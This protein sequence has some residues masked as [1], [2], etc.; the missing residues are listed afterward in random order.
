MPTKTVKG[1]KVPQSK[2]PLGQSEKEKTQAW[3]T[4]E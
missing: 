2:W 1:K 3:E 4:L